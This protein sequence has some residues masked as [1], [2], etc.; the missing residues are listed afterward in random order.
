ML[1]EKLTN[2]NLEA[3]LMGGGEANG[4]FPGGATDAT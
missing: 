1:K 4:K 2:L 3:L